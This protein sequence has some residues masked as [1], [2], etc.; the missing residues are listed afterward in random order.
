MDN[1]YTWARKRQKYYLCLQQSGEH[2]T[3]SWVTLATY[4]RCTPL[5]SWT[6]VIHTTSDA[7]TM[8]INTDTYKP[9]LK[10]MIVYKYRLL[11]LRTTWFYTSQG[12][13]FSNINF[14]RAYKRPTA[15]ICKFHFRCTYMYIQGTSSVFLQPHTGNHFSLSSCWLLNAQCILILWKR[16]LCHVTKYIQVYKFDIL[17]GKGSL[18]RESKWGFRPGESE[19]EALNRKLSYHLTCRSP[20]HWPVEGTCVPIVYIQINMKFTPP[21]FPG[22]LKYVYTTNINGR[23]SNTLNRQCLHTRY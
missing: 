22:I 15:L 23:R 4:M 16:E 21:P 13:Y 8:Y 17:Y 1:P 7:N 10:T 9:A 12:E 3:D 19:E 2:Q 6:S 5:S 14:P 18:K 11:I 20:V